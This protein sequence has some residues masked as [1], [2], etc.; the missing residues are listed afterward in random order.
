M[1][2]MLYITIIF[3]LFIIPSH[4][5]AIGTN[6]SYMATVKAD[7]VN[8]RN[9]ASSK[10]SIISSLNNGQEVKVLDEAFGWVQI[11]AN[12]VTGWV[13]GQYLS[14]NS[15]TVSSK[16][17]SA[18]GN[19]VR[20]R[21]GPGT[22]YPVLG[23]VNKGDLLTIMESKNGWYK[24]RTEIGVEGWIAKQ[25]VGGVGDVQTVK[26]LTVNAK[27][28]LAGKTIVIDPG[29]GG[30]DPGVIGTTYE[31]TEKELN[32][33]TALYLKQ[34]LR[35]LGATVI[36]TRTKN[37]EKP[38]LSDRAALASKKKADAFVSIHY[39]SSEKKT[40]GTL[41]FYYSKSKD[42]RLSRAIEGRLSQGIG[43]KSNGIAFGDYHVLREN[44]APSALVELGFL[45]NSKDEGIVQKSSYQK[46]AAQAIADGLADYFSWNS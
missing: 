3:C 31:T 4:A 12:G 16:Q 14:K 2:K 18:L 27:K 1:R 10:A 43:L 8:V 24:I 32:L 19:G 22:K 28:G 44:A 11:Q 36:M 40:S 29:H 38:S 34:E 17:A 37:T 39:N 23:S 46:K 13:A 9:E 35:A 41:T 6:S 42:Q 33:T 21:E 30:S 7:S 20:L 25:Y 5:L 45:S 26:Q 15:N